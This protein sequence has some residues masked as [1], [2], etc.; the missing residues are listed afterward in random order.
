[1]PTTPTLS[2]QG[3]REN[4]DETFGNGYHKLPKQS[5]YFSS[6]CR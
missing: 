6:P 4:K 3:A 2:L 5:G 1:M